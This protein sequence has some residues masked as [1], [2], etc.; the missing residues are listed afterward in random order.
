[1]S[2]GK[3]SKDAFWERLVSYLRQVCAER[4]WSYDNNAQRGWAFQFWIA[5]LFGKREG[6]DVSHD[7]HVFLNSD[8]GIDIILE[9]QDQKRYSFIQAKFL[10]YSA[11]IDEA[12]VSQLCDR[13]SLFLDRDWVKKHVKQEAQFDILGGYADLLKSGYSMHYYFIGTGSISDRLKDIAASRQLDINREEPAVSFDI[14]DLSALK[15]FYIEAETLEQNIPESVE[16][17]LPQG[18]FVIKDRP[19]K[20]LLAI[21]KGNA[22]VGLYKKERERLFSYN[23]RSYL[24]KKGLNKEIIN[25]AETNAGN[26]YYFNNGVSAICTSFQVS[27]LNIFTAQNF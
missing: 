25:T 14:M 22:L 13:H 9:D 4:G 15:E 20:T 16:F 19:Y 27:P 8:C 24:G 10:K 3:L 17:Q 7:E 18:S 23:I 12:D 6:I 1:M 11:S 26:F 21:V 2:Q 5:D